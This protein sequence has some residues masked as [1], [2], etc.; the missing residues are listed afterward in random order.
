MENMNIKRLQA[1]NNYLNYKINSYTNMLNTTDF[2]KNEAKFLKSHIAKMLN[3]KI[4]N[5][6]ILKVYEK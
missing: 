4:S 2:E 3:R 6:T 1:E 5:E